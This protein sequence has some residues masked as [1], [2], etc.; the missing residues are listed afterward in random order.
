[1][2]DTPLGARART[3]AITR[4]VLRWCLAQGWAP[5]AEVPLP[6]GRRA[7]VLA[8]RADGGLVIIEVKSGA[9]DYLS[10]AKW[11]DYAAWCDAFLFAVDL[12]F[13]EA[14]LPAEPGLLV[15]AGREAALRRAPPEAAL[16][17]ARRRAL[18][19]RLARLAATRLAEAA[20]P[21]GA[22]ERRAALRLA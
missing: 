9:R 7:D 17:P 16:A 12:D 5:L 19:L 13:P 6:D 22:A 15:V 18:T 21:E 3:E 1:M 8:I 11:G 14:L 10:D 4:A 2:S 20:D